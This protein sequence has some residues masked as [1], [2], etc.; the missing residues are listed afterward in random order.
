MLLVDPRIGSKGRERNRRFEET[1]KQRHGCARTTWYRR[2]SPKAAA[3]QRASDKRRYQKRRIDPVYL[4]KQKLRAAH[5]AK[6]LKDAA[7]AAYG[8]YVCLCCGETQHAFL[9]LDHV[10][11]D[12]RQHRKEV[13]GCGSGSRLYL[14]LKRHGYP[15]GMFQ[16]LC[17]NCN[18][19]KGHFGVCPHQEALCF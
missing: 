9:S 13:G 14:W 11:G 8:G 15:A 6:G 4:L 3:K 2:N 17:M 5:Y 12:G 19:A 1:F 7:Y 18:F 16:V 10:N